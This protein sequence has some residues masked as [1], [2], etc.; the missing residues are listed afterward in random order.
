M[1]RIILIITF[2]AAASNIYAKNTEFETAAFRMALNEKGYVVSLFDKV[3]NKEYLAASQAAPLLSI[4]CNGTMEA[5][6]QMKARGN[7]LTLHYIE[8]KV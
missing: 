5:P 7:T 3:N 4:R 2:L 8:N 1:R 6:S